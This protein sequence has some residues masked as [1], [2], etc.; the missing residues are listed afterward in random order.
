MKLPVVVIRSAV[1]PGV[2]LCGEFLGI[3]ESTTSRTVPHSLPRVPLLGSGSQY[4]ADSV[5]QNSV[6]SQ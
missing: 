2:L 4:F 1:A 5:V 3:N 6:Q